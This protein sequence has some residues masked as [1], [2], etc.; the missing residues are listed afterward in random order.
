MK[1]REIFPSLDQLS[2]DLRDLDKATTPAMNKKKR[3]CVGYSAW[4]MDEVKIVCVKAI[5][6]NLGDIYCENSFNITS[7]FRQSNAFS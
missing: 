3:N 7:D 2:N 6:L 5:H 1:C 4:L